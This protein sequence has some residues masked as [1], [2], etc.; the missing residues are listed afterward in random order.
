MHAQVFRTDDGGGQPR[1]MAYN[2]G[3]AAAHAPSPDSTWVE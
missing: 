3:F 1:A 2:S